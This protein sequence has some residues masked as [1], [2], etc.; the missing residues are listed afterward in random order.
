MFILNLL[1]LAS[2][3]GV[4]YLNDDK[5]VLYRITRTSLL[6][7]YEIISEVEEIIAGSKTDSAFSHCANK[8]GRISFAPGSK[9]KKI[10]DSLFEDTSITSC[11][12][13]NC[14]FLETLSYCCFLRCYKLTSL[15]LPPNI[16]TIED[17]SI[18]NTGLA[19]LV[20]PDSLEELASYTGYGCIGA[21]KLLKGITINKSSNLTKI[22][23]HSFINSGL[24]SFFIPKKVSQINSAPFLHTPLSKLE[25]D[26]ENPNFKTDESK[27]TIYDPSFQSIILVV[28]G[29]AIDYVINQSVTNV[30]NQ[31]FRGSY[32][33]SVTFT[34][35]ITLTDF[36]FAETKNLTFLEFPRG[37]T[38]ISPY[39][40][41]DSPI[42]TIILPDTV[43]TLKSYAFDRLR[44]LTHI[45]LKEGLVTIESNAFNSCGS[46]LAI[47]IPASVESLGSAIFNSCNPN[48]KVI[49]LNKTRFTSFGDIIIFE[50]KTIIDYFGN[51]E[52]SDVIVPN[53]ISSIPNTL[54][55]SKKLRSVSFEEGIEEMT[56]GES[57]FA[58]STIQ[59]I[60]LPSCL[61]S[62]GKRCFQHCSRLKEI[63]FSNTRLTFI[64][65][66]A[67]A[68]CSSLAT[69]IFG[70][71]QIS[72]IYKNAFASAKF[73][74]H[75]I[76]T[77]HI[78][79]FDESSFANSQIASIKFP[80]TLTTINYY[81]FQGSALEKVSFN[82]ECSIETL[83]KYAF[84]SCKRLTSVALCDS[85]KVLDESCFASDIHL[86][87]FT[88]SP[89]TVRIEMY[90]FSGC[91]ELVALVIPKESKLERIRPYAFHGCNKMTEIELQETDVFSFSNGCLMS[92]DK[93]KLI[94]YLPTSTR[95][96]IVISGRIQIIDQYAFQSCHNLREVFIPDGALS[97]IGHQA[98][99]DCSSLVR[100][101][102]PDTLSV[103]DTEAFLNCPKLKC[104]CV[105]VPKS[106]VPSAVSN[107][108][109]PSDILS[110]TCLAS[111]CFVAYKLNTCKHSSFRLSPLFFFFALIH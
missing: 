60:N 96:S 82:S 19:K 106:L 5:K 98:F 56:F 77:S 12:M 50:N 9:L 103:I 102:L 51:D 83:G 101:Q 26:P 31:A 11:D 52:N 87:K 109:I 30:K 14:E 99:E 89:N 80:E 95:K 63:N 70:N 74:V 61:T 8:I 43:T 105:T 49:F 94:Y 36:L 104:G 110:D 55:S 1:F 65:E 28:P 25:I 86:K 78:A 33:T 75:D 42:E 72:T 18:H 107:G 92:S 15:I 22:G 111:D 37:T 71:S 73:T 23:G 6:P 58:S 3:D 47:E 64:S 7:S 24:A 46:L 85:V 81:A 100:V 27:L 88:I 35:P 39:I 53:F 4:D 38:V 41:A 40:A 44:K 16:K 45:S 54:F 68:S 34:N 79:T 67:F 2:Y 69:V 108:K 32:F 93:T 17:G 29:I 84:S 97:T 66:F 59:Y 62:I 91:I 20:F 90:C 10:G 21:N 76:E 13:S 57:S 48:L